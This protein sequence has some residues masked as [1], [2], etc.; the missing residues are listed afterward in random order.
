V[1]AETDSIS[2]VAGHWSVVMLCGCGICGW[3]HAARNLIHSLHCISRHGPTDGRPA[4]G[5]C[6]GW[7]GGKGP[8]SK[9]GEMG[10]VREAKEG[11]GKERKGRK[12][13]VG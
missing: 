13:R 10:G 2:A 12:G 4:P 3:L 5:H 6:P 7:G 11:K 8:T 1:T 9:E